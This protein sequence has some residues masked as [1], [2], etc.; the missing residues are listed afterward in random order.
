MLSV[1]LSVAHTFSFRSTL[2]HKGSAMRKIG[3]EKEKNPASEASK[4]DTTAGVRHPILEQVCVLQSVCL[5]SDLS[6]DIVEDLSCS[7][8]S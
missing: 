5:S 7:Y 2:T 3:R 1:G 8:Y 6:A 4:Q